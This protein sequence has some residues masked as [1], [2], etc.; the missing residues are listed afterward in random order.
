[1]TT[2]IHLTCPPIS[3]CSWWGTPRLSWCFPD[4][5]C[6]RS[7]GGAAWT[8]W[9]SRRP[10]PSC[11]FC[12]RGVSR[13]C[14]AQT[15]TR[16]GRP[17]WWAPPKWVVAQTS[18]FSSAQTKKKK[19]VNE[20][21]ASAEWT[22]SGCA[23]TKNAEKKGW[24]WLGTLYVGF[25]SY[26][27]DLLVASLPNTRDVAARPQEVQGWW[28]VESEKRYTVKTSHSKRHRAQLNLIKTRL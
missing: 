21:S 27:T 5:H 3:L 28:W 17:S 22:L 26:L 7:E 12:H 11:C 9:G 13:D 19:K 16:S 25:W 18:L 2:N 24:L 20:S 4:L 1:M 14:W 8:G 6:S 23:F 10:G 15:P